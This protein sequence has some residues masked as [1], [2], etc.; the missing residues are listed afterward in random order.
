MNASFASSSTFRSPKLLADLGF[1]E[2]LVLWA[3]RMWGVGYRLGHSPDDVLAQG[4][5]KLG[6]RMAANVLRNLWWR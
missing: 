4:F 6:W 3:M 2:W 5:V 1:A